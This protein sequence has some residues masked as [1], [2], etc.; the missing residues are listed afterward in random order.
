MTGPV[1]LALANSGATLL[2]SQVVRRGLIGSANVMKLKLLRWL[3]G[4]LRG[5]RDNGP[6][7]GPV[8]GVRVPRGS[9][10]RGRGTAVAS[11]EP[12]PDVFVHAVGRSDRPV[13]K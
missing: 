9:A 5:D 11:M 4:V 7:L 1:G 13:R 3:V 10:P 2:D 12:E 6:G 8:A